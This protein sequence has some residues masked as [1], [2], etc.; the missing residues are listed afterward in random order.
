MK[1][2]LFGGKDILDASS[3]SNLNLF[4]TSLNVL[5]RRK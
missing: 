1:I 5:L 4:V 2:I 3:G